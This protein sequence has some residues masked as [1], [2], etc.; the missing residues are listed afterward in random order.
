MY[1]SYVLLI[2]RGYIVGMDSRW[3]P[4][5]GP[6]AIVSPHHPAQSTR[7]SPAQSDSL[8][9]FWSFTALDD[10]TCPNPPN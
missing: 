2:M 8:A 1:L 5:A 4:G 9:C 3:K 7:P 6:S 10:S